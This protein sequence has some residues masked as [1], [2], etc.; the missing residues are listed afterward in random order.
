MAYLPI[1]FTIPQYENYKNYWLK[2]YV[3]GT[4]TAKTMA[5]DSSGATT[6]AKFEIDSKG[7]PITDGSVRIIPY[8]DGAYDLWMFPTETA[9]DANNT[10][11]AIQVADNIT[12]PEPSDVGLDIYVG[13]GGGAVTSNTVV[14]NTSLQSPSNTGANLTLV[15]ENVLP[16]STLVSWVTAV[17]NG[18]CYTATAGSYNAVFGGKAMYLGT[19]QVG[20]SAFG[21]LCFYTGAGGGSNAGFGYRAG[22]LAT[23][24]KLSLFGPRAGENITTGDNIICIG[25]DSGSGIVANDDN[26]VIGNLAGDASMTETLLLG[27]GA[28]ERIKVDDDGLWVS[29][30]KVLGELTW[31]TPTLVNSWVSQTGDNVVEYVKSG[32]DVFI[33]GYVEGGSDTTTTEIFT[34]PSGYRPQKD[35]SIACAVSQG[36][37]RL[38]IKVNGTV[39]FIGIETHTGDANTWLAMTASFRTL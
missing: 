21:E 27:A 9:A 10:A 1:A 17:G 39:N 22:F 28:T 7:F 26:T 13:Y 18:A 6:A 8:I 15:G 36:T 23:G 4:T 31:L 38:Q 11:T 37:A 34:L 19:N 32:N 14:G 25:A 29:E 35:I 3:P 20:N 24:T 33:V 30:D 5:T 12:L 16:N 2:A